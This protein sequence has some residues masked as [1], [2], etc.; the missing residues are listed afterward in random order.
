MLLWESTWRLW[1]L[2]S[3]P[4]D[5][6]TG[7]KAAKGSCA[8]IML[9]SEWVFFLIA[10]LYFFPYFLTPKTFCTKVQPINN[11]VV[12]SGEQQRDS[13]IH[14]HGPLLPQT[15]LPSRL[16]HNIEQ[17]WTVLSRISEGIA[18][19][20]HSENHLLSHKYVLCTVLGVGM[21]SWTE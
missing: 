19:F 8:L 6:E 9:G 16:A 18:S 2:E 5:S 3:H 10:K 21:K 7:N 20:I 1:F 14:I 4:G 12:V 17:S 13:A 11:I 15:L